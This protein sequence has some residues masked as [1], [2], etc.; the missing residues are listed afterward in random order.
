MGR[1]KSTLLER[2]RS[3]ARASGGTLGLGSKVS[4]AE[5]AMLSQLESAFHRA[6]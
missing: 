6:S 2:A 1:M 4:K 5:A 3:V